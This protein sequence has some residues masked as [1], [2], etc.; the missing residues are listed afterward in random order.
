M[1]SSYFPPARA[2]EAESRPTIESAT[3]AAAQ[4]DAEAA[5]FLSAAYFTG[6]AVPQDDEKAVEFARQATELGHAKAQNNLGK[7]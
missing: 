2:P 1:L 3:A 5:F 4:G 6:K 7:F